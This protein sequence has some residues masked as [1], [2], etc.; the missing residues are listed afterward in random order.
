MESPDFLFLLQNF[1]ISGSLKFPENRTALPISTENDEY[2][3]EW[4]EI[5]YK[6][7]SGEELFVRN[8]IHSYNHIPLLFSSSLSSIQG[9][10]VYMP[11]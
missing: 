7:L 6:D 1:T 11:C 8:Q 4:E 5:K 3:C 9:L 2:D 10:S